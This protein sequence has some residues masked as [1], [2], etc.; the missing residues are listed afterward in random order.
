MSLFTQPLG[1]TAAQAQLA[2]L[3]AQGKFPH[4]VLL[5]GPQGVG[6]ATLARWLAARLICGP[7]AEAARNPLSPNQAT[8]VWAQLQAGSCPD[9]HLLTVPEKKKSIGVEEVRSL[10][11]TLLRSSEHARVVVVDALEHITPE[12]ANTLL[13]TLEEPRPGI[14]FILV[15]HQLSAV[16]PTLKSRCRL[17]K[18][19]VLTEAETTAVLAAQGAE[20][21]AEFTQIALAKGRPGVWLGLSAAQRAALQGLRAGVLPAASTPQLLPLLQQHLASLPPRYPVAQ[22]YAQLAKLQ[23]QQAHLNL[24]IALVQEQALKIIQPL[25][26]SYAD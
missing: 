16:L 9:F 23:N 11:E 2:Q 14:Y 20:L 21:A 17:I 13:K 7:A 5:H 1:H 19:G 4:A 10:L 8:P 22:A 26:V 24:P 15:C 18:L 25:L 3:L 12:A 6:K